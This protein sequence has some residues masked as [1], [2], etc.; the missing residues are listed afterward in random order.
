MRLAHQVFESPARFRCEN[1]EIP[2]LNPDWQ[3]FE[4]TE[5]R[6]LPAKA[7]FDEL[8]IF[9]FVH[10]FYVENLDRLLAR[11]QQVGSIHHLYLTTCTQADADLIGKLLQGHDHFW[12]NTTVEVVENRGRDQLPFWSALRKAGQGCDYFIK[13]H[14]KKSAQHPSRADGRTAAEVWMDHIF[15]SI[16]P[17]QNE[18]IQVL[19]SWMKSLGLGAVF[20]LPWPPVAGHG[21]GSMQLVEKAG[22]ICS[23]LGIDPFR[24]YA[25]LVFPVGNMFIGSVPVFMS[26]MEYFGRTD[27]YDEEPIPYDGTSLHAME[28]IYGT[29]LHSRQMSFAVLTPA[30]K[31]ESERDVNAVSVR[32]LIVFPA[33]VNRSGD[34]PRDK[35]FASCATFHFYRETSRL[36]REA[37][38]LES[39]V[40]NLRDELSSYRASSVLKVLKTLKRSLRRLTTGFRV[41]E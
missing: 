20:P 38:A 23:D 9:V 13:L 28:R 7:D 1:V 16:L 12:G 35:D 18:D 39:Q 2:F 22:Q 33:G 14:L 32:K 34:S 15:S 37:K 5:A 29:L 10:C 17:G 4:S 21:W 40:F 30:S 6:V 11:L 25:P 19:L 41:E 26:W 36:W 31:T 3:S 8:R 24:L 27:L